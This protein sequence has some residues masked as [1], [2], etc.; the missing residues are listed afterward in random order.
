MRTNLIIKKL[1][2]LGYKVTRCFSGKVMANKGQ[3]SYIAD[4]YNAL[5]KQIFN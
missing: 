4:S 2:K 1:E 5:Y 3:Q